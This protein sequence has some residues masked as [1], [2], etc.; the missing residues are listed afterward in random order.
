M[1]R[2]VARAALL[3]VLVIAGCTYYP[4]VPD[5]GGIRIRPMNG[6]AVR[7][8]AGLALYVDLES[9][10]KYGDAVIGVAAP[11]VAKSAALRGPAGEPV[12]RVEVPGTA[13]VR[14]APQGVHIALSDLTR[15]VAA[16][17]VVLVTLVFEKIGNVGA[18]TRVE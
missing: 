3:L 16:G 12:A 18:I 8:P 7:T 5:V 6:R 10:G 17:D 2:G 4:T 15:A 11:D 9:T 1:R 13:I 14:L